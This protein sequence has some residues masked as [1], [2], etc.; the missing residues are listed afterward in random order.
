MFNVVQCVSIP[1]SLT[2]ISRLW[3][4]HLCAIY[5]LVHQLRIYWGK[6]SRAVGLL[7]TCYLT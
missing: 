4:L 5:M 2:C 3:L 7:R 6:E 1:P